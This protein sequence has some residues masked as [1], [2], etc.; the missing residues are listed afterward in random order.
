MTSNF[1]AIMDIRCEDSLTVGW[2]FKLVSV[3]KMEIKSLKYWV[4][5]V[6]VGLLMLH[7]SICCSRSSIDTA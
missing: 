7:T 3:K 2:D 5:M 6:G 4:V 1:N